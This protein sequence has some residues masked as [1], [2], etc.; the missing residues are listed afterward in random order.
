MQRRQQLAAL[1]LVLLPAKAIASP[2]LGL[3]V[4]YKRLQETLRQLSKPPG[5]DERLPGSRL[6]DVMFG[7]RQPRW[8]GWGPDRGA[9]P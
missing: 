1:A 6:V 3:Q 7:C 8:V 4:T 5:Q 2:P 9:G